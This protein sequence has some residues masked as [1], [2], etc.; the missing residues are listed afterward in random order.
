MTIPKPIIVA[1]IE[2]PP[3][4]MIGNGDPTIG[5]KPKTMLILMVMKTKIAAPKL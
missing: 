2:D 4:D 5:S 1:S 3:Y